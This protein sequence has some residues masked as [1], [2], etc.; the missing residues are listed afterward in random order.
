VQRL[1]QLFGR[2]SARG[3]DLAVQALG[4]ALPEDSVRTLATA[5]IAV[6]MEAYHAG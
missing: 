3:V 6:L 1:R 5:Y 2:R 4:T